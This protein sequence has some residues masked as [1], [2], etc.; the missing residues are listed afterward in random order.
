MQEAERPPSEMLVVGL[1][2]GGHR[3]PELQLGLAPEV[4]WT[5]VV[6]QP[7]SHLQELKHPTEVQAA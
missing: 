3:L 1:Q 6:H 5:Q 4:E 7:G 2:L